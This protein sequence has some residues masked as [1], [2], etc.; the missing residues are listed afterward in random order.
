MPKSEII[1]L[2][3]CFISI[4]GLLVNCYLFYRNSKKFMETEDYSLSIY[5]SCNMGIVY[6]M[7]AFV[8]YM[9]SFIV[10]SKENIDFLHQQCLIDYSAEGLFF[11]IAG[12]IKIVSKWR[13]KY[14]S[15]KRKCLNCIHKKV[16]YIT[17][18]DENDIKSCKNF[19]DKSSLKE[20]DLSEKSIAKFLYKEIEKMPKL[21]SVQI[22]DVSVISKEEYEEKSTD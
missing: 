3:L 9:F 7:L 14:K 18:N 4:V 15:T 16:C 8:L 1:D 21:L 19:I 17:G 20:I 12:V 2:T 10:S 22:D 6:G 5:A 13:M 11:L